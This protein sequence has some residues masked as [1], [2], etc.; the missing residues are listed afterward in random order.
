MAK[1]EAT[2]LHTLSPLVS[3]YTKFAITSDGGISQTTKVCC[4][5]PPSLAI[6]SANLYFFLL[7]MN[8]EWYLCKY[9]NSDKK[10]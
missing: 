3:K 10:F 5:A 7:I 4:I 8:I 6:A 1:L 2:S 9:F